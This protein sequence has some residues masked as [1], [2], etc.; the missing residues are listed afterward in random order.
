MTKIIEVNGLTKFFGN[1]QAVKNI[2]FHVE[3]GTLFSFLGTNGAGKST[4]IS[5]L[6]TLLKHDKGEVKAR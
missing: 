3:E 4:T 2:S 6:L 5:I 1:V